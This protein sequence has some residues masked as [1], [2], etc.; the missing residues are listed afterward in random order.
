VP[1]VPGGYLPA[2][3]LHSVKW[4]LRLCPLCNAS[5]YD[6]FGSAGTV[7]RLDGDGWKAQDE[8]E[9]TLLPCRCQLR[10]FVFPTGRLAEQP[11]PLFDQLFALWTYY[12]AA[13]GEPPAVSVGA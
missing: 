5:F 3:M 12:N 4:L 6:A 7:H 1:F 2:P 13:D 8:V 9:L 10:M 11:M